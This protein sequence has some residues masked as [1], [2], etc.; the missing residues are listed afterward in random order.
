MSV[1][2]QRTL[3]GR[4]SLLRPVNVGAS[5]AAEQVGRD[6]EIELIDQIFL[7]ESAEK[8]RSSFAGNRTHPIFAPELFQHPREIDRPRG[9][10]VERRFLPEQSS[11]NAPA[12]G[13]WKR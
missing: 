9:A 12:C 2:E 6:G 3:R 1:S 13:R 7:E 11:D 8:C 10:Q 5:R 4:K